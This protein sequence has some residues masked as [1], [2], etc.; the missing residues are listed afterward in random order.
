M[1][2][3]GSAYWEVRQTMDESRSMRIVCRPSNEALRAAA[4]R[5]AGRGPRQQRAGLKHE[6]RCVGL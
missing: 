4:G 6:A 5:P 3:I 2:I 1:F